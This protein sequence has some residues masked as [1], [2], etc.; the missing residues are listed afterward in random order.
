MVYSVNSTNNRK[1]NFNYIEKGIYLLSPSLE[2]YNYASPLPQTSAQTFS[3]P[4]FNQFSAFTFTTAN[5]MQI[6]S[7]DYYI[8]RL[9]SPNALNINSNMPNM[10][11]TSAGITYGNPVQVST[12]VCLSANLNLIVLQGSTAQPIP[13]GGAQLTLSS[14]IW[15]MPDHYL[16]DNFTSQLTGL[17]VRDERELD[18][19]ACYYLARHTEYIQYT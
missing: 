10:K 6:T 2:T 15:K 12:T 1:T 18:A 16:N 8:L 17:L 9:V 11:C 3:N 19:F 4:Y 7:Q 14:S 13:A 5:S